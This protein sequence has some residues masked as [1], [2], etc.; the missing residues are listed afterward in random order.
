MSKA[1]W[2]I[3][4]PTMRNDG[5]PIKTRFHRVWDEKVRAI[6][7]GLTIMPPSKG[8]WKSP[9]GKLF[10]ERMIPVRIVA[11]EEEIDKII[12][13][14]IE[15]YEQEAVLAYKL[16]DVVK[17]KY[18]PDHEPKAKAEETTTRT[19]DVIKPLQEITWKKCFE[20]MSDFS[21]EAI[22]SVRD[23]LIK[24]NQIKAFRCGKT[25]VILHP[26]GLEKNLCKIMVWDGF[27]YDT[28]VTPY[29]RLIPK[30]TINE[31]VA[32]NQVGPTCGPKEPK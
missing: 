15:Y 3:L 9:N 25:I 12:D 29:L 8:Q 16:S 19:D 11:T 1:M 31:L 26:E 32:P 18:H 6:S 2:E 28:D 14:T 10:V 21:W 7:D 22:A 17:L 13:M 24:G 30:E 5:R 27:A 20:L 4:V 23:R